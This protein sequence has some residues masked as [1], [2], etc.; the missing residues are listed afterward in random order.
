MN[1]AIQ[2]VS[3]HGGHSGQFCL[4]AS[5]TLEEVIK[6]Y[7][8]AGYT[9]VG[10]TE[11]MPPPT[12]EFRY[13]DEAEA[14]ISANKLQQQFSEYF[15]ECRAL[16]EK[17]KDQI[18]IYTSFETEM[19]EGAV[20]YIRTLVEATKPD[21]LVG[22]VHHVGG[23]GIDYSPELYQ[24]AQEKAGSLEA[25]YCQYFD[26]QYQLLSALTPAVVGHF[27]LIR[28]FDPDY[29]NTLTLPEVAQR[30]TRNLAFI[31]QQELILDFNLRG[32][33]KGT[34]PYPSIDVLR[35]AVAMGISIV[36]GDDSH[37]ISS[38][39]KHYDEG[40]ELLSSLGVSC[41]WA[42]PKLLVSGKT[43]ELI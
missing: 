36:P 29:Q 9:W 7:I 28:I 13:L 39:G 30:I 37:G 11:H 3:V 35:Q 42:R 1:K 33:K 22:S 40:I 32:Y 38:V 12:D 17:Y 18:E 15:A 14:N 24:Q 41:E 25:L 31:K 10:I 20:D 23:I 43:N 5:N 16:K 8:D 21:Y 2:K 26:A 27:D 19:Y 6:A 34:E 4:H